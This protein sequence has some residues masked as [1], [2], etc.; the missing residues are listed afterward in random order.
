MEIKAHK[1]GKYCTNLTT[2]LN[3]IFTLNV[4]NVNAYM[5]AGAM[6]LVGFSGSQLRPTWNEVKIFPNG[7]IEYFKDK[8][9]V[10]ESTECDMLMGAFGQGM[11][12]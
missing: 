10:E 5:E 3:G 8:L 7:K 9:L 12:N 4:N 11:L 6:K 1:W 2:L